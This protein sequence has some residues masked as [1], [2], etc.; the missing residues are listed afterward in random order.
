MG[1]GKDG[2]NCEKSSCEAR[3]R[4]PSAKSRLTRVVVDPCCTSKAYLLPR[5]FAI[6]L[7]LHL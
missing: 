7:Q 4:A 3:A 2:R 5:S 1:K 6:H